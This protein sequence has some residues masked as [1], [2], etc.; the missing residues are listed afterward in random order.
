MVLSD[1]YFRTFFVKGLQY[2]TAFVI[3]IDSH[4]YLV[5]ARHLVD[6]TA[7]MFNFKVFANDAW[8]EVEALAV[9]H[10]SGEID[11][12]LYEC[13]PALRSAEFTLLPAEGGFAL[14]Q[15]MFF[16]GFPYKMWGNLRAFLDGR[17]CAFVKRGTLSFFDTYGE[18]TLFVDAIN[19]EGFSGGPL[20]FY[21]PADP[22]RMF[23]AGIVSK[24]K[25][26]HEP[27]IDERGEVTAM[28]VPYNT[29]FMVAYG[30]ANVI[31]IIHRARGA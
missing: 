11:I 31:N 12:S 17:P 16:L 21:P 5:T 8:S 24:F 3:R 25:V 28:Q 26:E 20:L 9:G 2:G 4:E 10:G 30:M 23:V 27:V 6:P 7:S 1:A 29:G 15:D 14:G 22:R 19:N 18:R 13:P